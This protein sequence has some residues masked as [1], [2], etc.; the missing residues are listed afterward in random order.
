MPARVTRLLFDIF[1]GIILNILASYIILPR[2]LHLRGNYYNI[3]D[4][5]LAIYIGLILSAIELIVIF[6]GVIV[7]V[8]S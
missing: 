4:V 3:N 8:D 2:F 1:L 7:F 6:I 5:Y